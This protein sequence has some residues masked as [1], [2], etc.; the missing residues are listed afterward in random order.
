MKKGLVDAGIIILMATVIAAIV[1]AVPEQILTAS[2]SYINEDITGYHLQ[3]IENNIMFMEE[4]EKGYI[5]SEM[6]NYKL[7]TH[8]NTLALR[9]GEIELSSDLEDVDFN[10]PEEYEEIDGYICISKQENEVSLKTQRCNN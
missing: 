8:E 2:G 3:Q 9:I 10:G 1:L 7:K 6:P 4:K 5:E